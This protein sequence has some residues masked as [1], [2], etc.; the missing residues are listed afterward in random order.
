MATGVRLGLV[1]RV[2]IGN[3]E[4]IAVNV[5]AWVNQAIV[6]CPLTSASP[7]AGHV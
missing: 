2:L 1:E 5:S 3:P 6:N 7:G 4:F